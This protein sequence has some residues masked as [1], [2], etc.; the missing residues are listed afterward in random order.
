MRKEETTAAK[1]H[2]EAV[3]WPRLHARRREGRTLCHGSSRKRFQPK[4]SKHDELAR[5]QLPRTILTSRQHGGSMIPRNI[6]L[7]LEH[8]PPMRRMKSRKTEKRGA[9]ESSWAHHFLLIHEIAR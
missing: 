6:R 8:Q 5:E 1:A 3:V 7:R 9:K 2:E 4:T